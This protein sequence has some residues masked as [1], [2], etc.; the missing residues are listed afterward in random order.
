M[1]FYLKKYLDSVE[2]NII[3]NEA[4]IHNQ[5]CTCKNVSTINNNISDSVPNIIHESNNKYT[6]NSGAPC[7]SPSNMPKSYADVVKTSSKEVPVY[8]MRKPQKF[9]ICHAN[10]NSNLVKKVRFKDYVQTKINKP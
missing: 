3:N 9:L 7:N 2:N 6:T 1:F 10:K 8:V 5:D 4:V